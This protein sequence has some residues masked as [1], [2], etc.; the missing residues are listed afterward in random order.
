MAEVQVNPPEFAGETALGTNGTELHEE[1]PR[2]RPSNFVGD[3]A[4]NLG[5]RIV[6][7]PSNPR[8]R[9]KGAGKGVGK[10]SV[11]FLAAMNKAGSSEKCFT[12]ANDG[13]SEGRWTCGNGTLVL[14]ES[15]AETL[16]WLTKDGRKSKWVRAP[17]MGPVYFDPLPGLKQQGKGFGAKGAGKATQGPKVGK[18][19]GAP[20]WDATSD[21][22][23][24]EASNAGK[25][26]AKAAKSGDASAAAAFFTSKLSA[27]S[28]VFRPSGLPSGWGVSSRSLVPVEA[29]GGYS[30]AGRKWS[31]GDTPPTTSPQLGPT[32]S[33]GAPTQNQGEAKSEIMVKTLSKSRDITISGNRIEWQLP[34]SWGTLRQYGNNLCL[35]SPLFGTPEA[36]NMQ[37]SFYPNGTRT[38]EPGQ[39]TIMLNRGPDGAGIKFEVLLNGKGIGPKVCIGRRYLGDYPMPFPEGPEHE[40]KNVLISMQ[41][42][43]ILG[44]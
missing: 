16:T 7:T 4:D 27:A 33:P 11:G 6:V 17:P 41:V 18:S 10:N 38:T 15:D 12:I 5:H 35:T 42:L 8:R 22:T 9:G 26:V 43:D 14:E 1:A 40:E 25:G 19:A 32:A 23:P 36:A 37:L 20:I 31:W 28:P 30:M 13:T 34:E 39:C 24:A 44:K 2:F 29:P 3:W 21:P